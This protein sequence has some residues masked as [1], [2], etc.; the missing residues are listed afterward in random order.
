MFEVEMLSG[1]KVS[2]AE[3]PIPIDTGN[4]SQAPTGITYQHVKANLMNKS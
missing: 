1:R 3:V 4:Y 2:S